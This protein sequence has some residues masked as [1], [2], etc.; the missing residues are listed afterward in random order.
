MS[1][2]D[3]FPSSY[4]P[5]GI[6]VFG[7]DEKLLVKFYRHAELSQHKSKQEGRPVY[8]D[9]EMVSV[10]QPGEKDE[11][12]VLASDWHRRRF[13]RQYEAFKNGLEQAHTG[14]PIELLLP[15]EPSTVLALKG[16]NVFTVEQLAGISDTAMNNIPMGRT[17]SERAQKY[18]ASAQGGQGFHQMEAMQKQIEELKAQLAE[19]PT[20]A[21]AAPQPEQRRGPGRPPKAPQGEE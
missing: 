5:D 3:F 1:S 6:A 16:N 10:I 12:K 18:L 7:T 11:V 14:T 9:W 2:L 19:R 13:P 8:D 21:Q 4:T 17:L 15:A 20:E